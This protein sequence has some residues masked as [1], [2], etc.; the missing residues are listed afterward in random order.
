MC[1]RLL[2]LGARSIAAVLVALTIADAQ[3]ISRVRARALKS[4]TAVSPAAPPPSA[5]QLQEVRR[6]IKRTWTVLTRSTRDLPRAVP[7]PKMR[8]APGEAWP[9][10]VPRDEDRDAIARSLRAV[11]TPGDLQ[12]I[13]LRPLPVAVDQ[14]REH[15]LLYLPHRYVVP[16][17]RF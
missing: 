1:H 17:G 14:I 7:D 16:G 11:L 15:G 9:L 6:Y 8:R 12:R 10:Y 4:Q 13:D 2:S 3:P 5:S